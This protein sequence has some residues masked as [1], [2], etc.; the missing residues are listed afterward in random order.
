[1]YCLPVL[2][3]ETHRLDLVKAA[4]S[5]N[6][7]FFLGTDTAPHAKE[8]KVSACG[9]A[10]SVVDPCD[11]PRCGSKQSSAA[12]FGVWIERVRCA[13]PHKF[14]TY[15]REDEASCSS[16]H[17]ARCRLR[18][19]LHGPCSSRAVLRGIRRRRGSRQVRGRCFGINL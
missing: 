1:M 16:G 17:F 12:V 9:E 19:Y 2:K 5:G 8:A 14:V 11:S 10:Y 3:R 4:T 6:P 18:W 7:K 13:H 15:Y